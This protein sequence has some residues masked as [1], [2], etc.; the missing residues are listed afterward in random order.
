MHFSKS[1]LSPREPAVEPAM[2]APRTTQSVLVIVAVA[3]I[4]GTIH[5][6]IAEALYLPVHTRI[7]PSFRIDCS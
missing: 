7:S 2:E 3:V 1:C 4:I 6:T 5:F